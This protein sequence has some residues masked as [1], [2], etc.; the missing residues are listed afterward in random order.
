MGFS[1]KITEIKGI[2][3]R[4]RLPRLGKLRQGFKLKGHSSR[5]PERELEYPC[6]LPFFVLPD[7]VARVYGDQSPEAAKKMLQ[8]A[9]EMGVREKSG[10]E[11]GTPNAKSVL[12]YISLNAW[13]LCE[14]MEIMLPINEIGAVFPQA[15]KWYGSSRGA[16]CTG[17]GV[18]AF[19]YDEQ[20]KT[21]TQIKCPCNQLKTEENTRGQCDMRGHLQFLIP[22]VSLGGIFQID[23]SSYN[24]IVDINSGID[25]VTAL[26]GRF[27]MVPMIIR[28]EP[29]DTHHGGS[30]QVHFPIKL[31]LH[32]SV[33]IGE[34][35]RLKTD[36]VRILEKS[37]YALPP[38]EDVNPEMDTDAGSV[39]SGDVD[40]DA[41]DALPGDEEGQERQALVEK[42]REYRG[43]IK[44]DV[45]KKIR[46]GY[47][48]DLNDTYVDVVKELVGKLEEAVRVS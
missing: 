48:S 8:R 38:V 33:G 39:M 15:Y 11:S 12:K 13:R 26:I 16:K 47:P 34:L 21:T 32:P 3:D 22:K 27:A 45:Y 28:K 1:G 5:N 40:E 4:R 19:R 18:K 43:Q 29:K 35:N 10:D 31:L 25:Y 14:E 23:I 46:E 44:P 2:S 37:Q 30:K 42:I 36:T 41:P 9:Q 17:D 6:E 7:A 24:S 20:K